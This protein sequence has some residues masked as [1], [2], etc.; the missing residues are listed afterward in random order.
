METNLIMC[1][2]NI[3]IHWFNNDKPTIQ[4]LQQIGLEKI[5]LSVITLMELI[6][7]VDN[8]AQLKQLMLKLKYSQQFQNK[9]ENQRPQ[10]MVLNL[11][12]TTYSGSLEP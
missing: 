4:K 6:Q 3:F 10:I 11:Q 2:T 9:P 1:D 12:N 5:A 7:G 8:K